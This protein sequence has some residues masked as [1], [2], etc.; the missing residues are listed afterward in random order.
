MASPK[1]KAKGVDGINQKGHGDRCRDTMLR[2]PR[3]GSC[4]GTLTEPLGQLGAQLGNMQ[5]TERVTS[6]EEERA[7]IWL[8]RDGMP[9]HCRHGGHTAQSFLSGKLTRC[10]PQLTVCFL[11]RW[12][13]CPCSDGTRPL[14]KSRGTEQEPGDQEGSDG[15]REASLHHLCILPLVGY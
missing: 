2:V 6:R 15:A 1:S 4:N 7:R 14:A 8:E 10:A 3:K 11:F 12:T 5:G 9:P 13:L